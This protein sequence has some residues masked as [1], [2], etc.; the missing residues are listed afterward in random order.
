MSAE[1]AREAFRIASTTEE[2]L[3]DGRGVEA[4]ESTAHTH[5]WS[6]YVHTH[7]VA[8]SLAAVA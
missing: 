3:E 8:T 6:V 4:C 1:A 5:V 2:H 7:V